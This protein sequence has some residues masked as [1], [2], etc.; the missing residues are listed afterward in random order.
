[1]P[2]GFILTNNEEGGGNPCVRWSNQFTLVVPSVL[3]HVTLKK[4][5]ATT[6]FPVTQPEALVLRSIRNKKRYIPAY[7]IHCNETMKKMGESVHALV[8]PVHTGGS[9]RPLPRYL[10]RSRPHHFPSYL[11]IR[12]WLQKSSVN[13]RTRRES[14]YMP[15]SGFI[16]TKR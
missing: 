10:K 14:I 3:L 5:L 8:K 2:A 13:S 9:I 7:Q 12:R 15:S 4:R 16:A 11:Y 6:S 1:M